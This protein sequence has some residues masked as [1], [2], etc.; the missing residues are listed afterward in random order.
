MQKILSKNDNH[1]SYPWQIGI[2]K[3]EEM[4]KNIRFLIKFQ[5]KRSCKKIFLLILY[6]HLLFFKSFK[7]DEF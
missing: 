2:N 7:P 1:F 6:L 5:N 4:C 3:S